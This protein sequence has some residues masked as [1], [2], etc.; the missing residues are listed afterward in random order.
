MIDS[1]GAYTEKHKGSL[2]PPLTI[3]RSATLGSS[4]VKMA[5]YRVH[6]LFIIGADDKPAGILTL[7]HLMQFVHK[8]NVQG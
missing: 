6:Q 5:M 7:P 1:V 3:R 4:F 2:L 8:L